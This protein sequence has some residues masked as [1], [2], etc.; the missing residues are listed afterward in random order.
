MK[1]IKS[2]LDKTYTI[3]DCSRSNAFNKSNNR[4]CASIS[5]IP[6][7]IGTMVR[8]ENYVRIPLQNMRALLSTDNL[9]FIL[10]IFYYFFLAVLLNLPKTNARNLV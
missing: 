1:E 7:N 10:N 6:S 8:T 5:E 2:F 9:V 4:D 3:F